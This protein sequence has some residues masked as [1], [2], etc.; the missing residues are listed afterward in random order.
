MASVHVSPGGLVYA[1]ALAEAVEAEGSTALLQDV[2]GV[3]TSLCQAW[4]A[5]PIFR[6]YFL[7]AEVTGA[8]K[9][10]TMGSLVSGRFPT[11]LG[12]FLRLL[13]QRRRLT[14]LPEIGVAFTTILDEKLGRV[15]VTLTTAVPVPESDFRAWSDIIRAAV[16]K[17]TVIEHIVSPEILAGCIIRLGDHVADGSARR[18]LADMHKQIIQRGKQHYALQS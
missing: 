16:G 8:Q 18:R 7:A 9:L 13:L 1:R 15:P 5:D 3:L 17:E 14:M 6:S 12:N 10:A 4:T 2:G 11:L